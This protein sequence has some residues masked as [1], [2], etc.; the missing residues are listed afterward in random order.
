MARAP[1]ARRSRSRCRVCLTPREAAR[2]L[3]GRDRCRCAA[4]GCGRCDDWSRTRLQ[5]GKTTIGHG[6]AHELE[7]VGRPERELRTARAAK[8]RFDAGEREET[9]R[10]LTGDALTE[11]VPCA[12]AGEDRATVAYELGDLAQVTEARERNAC[13][14]QRELVTRQHQVGAR[15]IR[16]P[17]LARCLE[18]RVVGRVPGVT[19]GARRRQR[20]GAASGVSG[21]GSAVSPMR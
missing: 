12:R 4:G 20:M 8:L 7:A 18:R 10:H 5:N 11:L 21:A 2:H 13:R 1:S 16:C 6:R 3:S 15:L 14:L 19:Y 17:W 9:R